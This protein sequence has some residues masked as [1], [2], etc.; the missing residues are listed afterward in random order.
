MDDVSRY[1]AFDAAAGEAGEGLLRAA[2]RSLCI[3]FGTSAPYELGR[4]RAQKIGYA[5][6]PRVVMD[7]VCRERDVD[8]LIPIVRQRVYGELAER[9]WDDSVLAFRPSVGMDSRRRAKFTDGNESSESFGRSKMGCRM[10][11]GFDIVDAEFRHAT[12]RG[13]GSFASLPSRGGAS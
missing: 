3:R 11:V 12:F 8:A 4:V 10:T 5:Q 6:I 1:G 2:H 7:V 13:F 9:G